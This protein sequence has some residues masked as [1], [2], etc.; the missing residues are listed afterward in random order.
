M[1]ANRQHAL[2]ASEDWTRIY[3]AMTKIKF[4]GYDFR[5][6]VGNIVDYI[7]QT[8]PEEYND[9]VV[10]SEFVMKVE[11]MAWL[12]QNLAFRLDLN[13]RE[14]VLE[15]AERKRSLINLAHMVGYKTSRLRAAEGLVKVVSVSTTEHIIDS[16]GVDI[17]NRKIMWND[18]RDPD[19]YERFIRIMDAALTTRTQFRHPIATATQSSVKV[20]QYLMRSTVPVTGVFNYSVRTSQVSTSVQIHNSRLDEQYGTITEVPPNPFDNMSVYYR[21]DGLGYGSKNTGF[22]FPVTEGRLR[23]TKITLGDNVPAFYQYQLGNSD[24]AEGDVFVQSVDSFGRVIADWQEVLSLYGEGVTFSTIDLN[25]RKIF[26]ILSG[27]NDT[28]TLQFGDGV[29]GEVP[30]GIL[31]VWYRTGNPKPTPINDRMFGQKTL[32][33]TYLKDNQQYTLTMVIKLHESLTG[34]MPS[35]RIADLKDRVGRFFYT[36]NR[37][38]TGQDYNNLFLTDTRIKKVRAVNHSFNGQSRYSKLVDPAGLYENINQI[39]TDGRMFLHIF[40]SSVD[41]EDREIINAPTS[42]VRNTISKMIGHPSVI[43]LHNSSYPDV[44]LNND[45]FWKE[46]HKVGKVSY[47]NFVGA[48]SQVVKIGPNSTGELSRFGQESYVKVGSIRGNIYP[49]VAVSG[50]GDTNGA[51]GIQGIRDGDRIHSFKPDYRRSFT[52]QEVREITKHLNNRI[53]FGIT[54]DDNTSSW[55]IIGASNLDETRDTFDYATINDISGKK[56][57]SAWIVMVQYIQGESVPKWRI[58]R[59]GASIGFESERE[60]DFFHVN[61]DKRVVDPVSGNVRMDS[62]TVLPHNETKYSL[63]R[64]GLNQLGKVTSYH[65]PMTFT[66]DGVNKC[67]K[68]DWSPLD[69]KLTIV[70]K[71]DQLQVFESEYTIKRHASGDEVCF[72]KPPKDGERVTIFY[73][74]QFIRGQFA[75]ASFVAT[76]ATSLYSLGV[77]CVDINNTIVMLDS[78]VQT[79][80]KDYTLAVGDGGNIAVYFKSP[81]GK[82]TV[83]TINFVHGIHGALFNR[84]TKFIPQDTATVPVSVTPESYDTTIL[85]IDGVVQS[86]K[87]FTFT[88]SIAGSEVT[89]DPPIPANTTLYTITLDGNNMCD[90]PLMRSAS[91]VQ[92]TDGTTRKFVVEPGTNLRSD[93]TG[94]LVFLD[95]IYQQGP[96]EQNPVWHVDGDAVLF[97]TAPPADLSL[98]IYTVQEVIGLRETRNPVANIQRVAFANTAHLVS[99]GSVRYIDLGSSGINGNNCLVWFDSVL[100]YQHK[101]WSIAPMGNG[102]NAIVF[103]SAVPN[104][105]TITVHYFANTDKSVFGKATYTADGAV[106]SF[107]VSKEQTADT[108]LVAINGIM[109]APSTYTIT[110]KNGYTVVTMNSA[111]AAGVEV[112]IIYAYD[113]STVTAYMHE[114]Y[115]D[116]STTTFNVGNGSALPNTGSG[117]IVMLDGVMQLGPTST[118]P[119]WSVSGSQVVFYTAPH[120]NSVVQIFF[121]SNV[122]GLDSVQVGSDVSDDVVDHR[123]EA[124][125]KFIGR[126]VK[127]TPI[128]NLYHVDGYVNQNGLVVIPADADSDG[129]IDYPTFFQ[130]FTIMDG[131]SDLVLW[132][133]MVRDG[134]DTWEPLGPTTQPRGFYG[135][136]INGTRR[137]EGDTV[138]MTIYQKDDIFYD[139]DGD[140]WLYANAETGLWERVSDQTAYKHAIGRNKIQFRWEHYAPDSHRIDPAKS[141]II[142]VFILTQTFHD[143]YRN[144]VRRN[145]VDEAAPVPETPDQLRGTFKD[146]DRFKMF[147]DN[148]IFHPVRFKPLFGSRAAPELQAY[149]DVVQTP[150]SNIGTTD[151]KIRILSVIDD[152]FDVDKWNIGEDGFYFSELAAYV[153]AKLSPHV[154]SIVIRP[155]DP[156]RSF[157]DLFKIRA[158]P[159]EMFVSVAGVEDI[160][161]K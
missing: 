104:G 46:D 36:Q 110:K 75:V 11:I 76:G 73:D 112:Q 130:D 81:P 83:V 120:V 131:K 101:D 147:S 113:P 60:I 160:V 79:P 64:R 42:I 139:V 59:K 10:S 106:K 151:L 134:I 111:P 156:T 97:D 29:Y 26:E 53:N 122:Q 135:S 57:N 136:N 17:A 63:N 52:D 84:M 95:G 157:G 129:R 61:Y 66:G 121:L 91:K 118:S 159:D 13:V 108:I 50:S 100:Q 27:E 37:M 145:I 70:L 68:V 119:A 94:T 154:Q 77:Q 109:Q 153:H 43:Q 137:K 146:F 103:N 102:N 55:K 78:V 21:E 117:I 115:G 4:S 158:E 12:F 155:K 116:G 123:L 41:E 80:L 8:H 74:S 138:D 82:D 124:D 35:E 88:N 44:I 140:V 58:T 114:Y 6:L 127:M 47:G 141:N 71:D 65:E 48:G 54:W 67:F 23:T 33:M 125:A 85:H 150:G 25:K 148:I 96:S 132:Q 28:V 143:A 105:V 20:S 45:I 16:N 90:R 93:G 62:I 126:E 38:V 7:K 72:A 99:D 86:E 22:F 128:D 2:F 39:G 92:K 30:S 149:F 24:I 32:T 9:F 89:F 142:H 14:N 40:S 15:T 144:W 3:E 133:R 49:V 107:T 69:P 51:I 161:V 56:N 5:E 34:G 152:Y 98:H 18:A 19:W 31:N 1:V 87:D